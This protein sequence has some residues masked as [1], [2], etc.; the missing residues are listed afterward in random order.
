MT[1]RSVSGIALCAVLFAAPA[2]AQSSGSGSWFGLLRASASGQVAQSVSA[3]DQDPSIITFDARSA[4]WSDRFDPSSQTLSF[5]FDTRQPTLS[6]L[7]ADNIQRAIDVYMGIAARGGWGTVPDGPVLRVGLSH[8]NVA[9]LRQRLIASGDLSANAGVSN[10]FD[11]YVEAAVRRFQMRHGL[12]PDGLVHDQTLVELNV[13]VEVRIEQ[14]RTN[15]VRVRSMSGDLGERYVMVNIPAAE[16]EAVENGVVASRHTAVVGREDRQSPLLAKKIQYISFN[17]FWTVPKSIIQKDII[18]KM[19]EDPTYLQRYKIRIFTWRGEEIDPANVDWNSNEAVDYML[20]Q[21]PG[22]QNSLGSIRINFPNEHAVYLH[23]TPQQTLFGQNARFHSSGCV[24]V[25]NVRQ[26]VDW[27]LQPNGDWS[28]AKI[29]TVVRSGET[30]DVTLKRQ[31]PI[32][33][34]YITAWA[35]SDGVV[36]FRPD[37]YNR[38]GLGVPLAASSI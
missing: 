24:R 31:T 6:A 3:R 2:M 20:K 15:L 17:P 7:T 29:D 12:V 14:L 9:A 25:Q 8:K 16:V 5:T 18:P 27:L 4:E 32:Y 33:F 37:V 34:A 23:D 26:L 21:D 28:R 10:T 38:D 36:H 30:L 22:D 35:T 13:P 19:R 11:T 1:I